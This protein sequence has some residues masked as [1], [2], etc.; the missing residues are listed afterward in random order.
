M[1]R[2]GHLSA[3]V[4]SRPLFGGWFL[5]VIALV[6]VRN[7]FLGCLPNAVPHEIKSTCLF[8]PTIFCL[9]LFSFIVGLCLTSQHKP[10]WKT[11]YHVV[12]YLWVALPTE[13]PAWE[14][15]LLAT[16][17][18]PAS[19]LREPT[20]LR[21]CGKGF[22]HQARVGIASDHCNNDHSTHRRREYI[23]LTFF[24]AAWNPLTF[25]PRKFFKA[26]SSQMA[27]NGVSV[28]KQI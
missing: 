1:D 8:L 9:C 17:G 11:N 15:A 28:L 7:C 6:F 22:A 2:Q 23:K 12:Y 10:A 18:I 20:T 3:T 5:K 19:I 26:V 24:K 25:M 13:T 4:G 14:T 27:S 21:H 16:G